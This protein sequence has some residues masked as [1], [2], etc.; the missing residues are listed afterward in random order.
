MSDNIKKSIVIL[1]GGISG[2][3]FAHFYNSNDDYIILEKEKTL[4][5][6]C[7]SFH[8]GQ[9]TFDFSGHFLHFKDEMMGNYIKALVNKHHTGEFKPYTRDAGI[10][11]KEG[12]ENHI[13][14]YP[15]QANIHQLE[16]E[17]FIKCLSD[18]HDVHLL[19]DM[20]ALGYDGFSSF[21]DAVIQQFGKTITD[22]FF[23]P[24][25]EKLYRTNLKDLDA[26]AMKRFIPKVSF[27]DVMKNIKEKK[28]F[29]YN[30]TFLY[31]PTSGIQ[32]LVDALIA[33]KP[34]NALTDETIIKIELEK[35]LIHTDKRLVAYDTLINTLPL[36]TFIKL[37]DL[38]PL[39]LK[40]VDVDVYNIS[41]TEDVVL[42]KKKAWLY[43]PGDAIFYRVGF[44]NFMSGKKE[45]S[46]YVEVS[47]PTGEKAKYSILEIDAELKRVGV[48]AK[49][50]K[51]TD[52][53]FLQMSPAY[54]ILERN[55]ESDVAE[56][57]SQ[58]AWSDVYL[59][60]RYGTWD[61]Q[62]IEDNI[63]DAKKLACKLNE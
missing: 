44:Y 10:F 24:Y 59:T 23:K 30:S 61:Y 39:S 2:I 57:I 18:L 4:G 54:A 1:G 15:F 49:D 38:Q 8:I 5:G 6:L 45:T 17:T 52:E 29:G 60:G 16:K 48:I 34:V 35:K 50:A 56:L 22:I 21:E 11:M 58:L 36:T 55:T 42:G 14:D 20:R 53:Q 9:S 25:N 7:R 33:E 13:I 32:G 28:E 19:D 63:L 40:S 62:S 37:A 3:S 51:M 27:K 43:F 12:T 31:S 46:M 41:Y 26:N 47:R